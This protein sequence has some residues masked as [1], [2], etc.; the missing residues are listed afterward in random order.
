VSDQRETLLRVVRDLLA[1]LVRA[2]GGEIYVIRAD[3]Q[4][5]AIHL[6]GRY[7]GCPGNNLARR[8]VIEPVLRAAI[9]GTEVTITSGVLVPAAAERID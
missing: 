8:R 2:D 1:P 6:A 3:A 4:G 7:A 9:P 5:I